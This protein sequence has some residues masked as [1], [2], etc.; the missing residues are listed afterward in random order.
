MRFA[1]HSSKPNVEPRVMYVRGEHRIGM[2]AKEDIRAQ[3][4]LFF[5]YGYD[6]EIRSVSLLKQAVCADWMQDST[7]A[8]TISK[9]VGL[10]LIASSTSD[11]IENDDDNDDD[12]D[13]SRSS[14]SNRK[15]KKKQKKD[16]AEET[17]VKKRS[18]TKV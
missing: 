10:T 16:K 8:N 6:T 7:L 1:N 5:D 4:E 2:F 15:K 3:A 11:T 14:S 9:H 13:V 12:N 17:R 18:R